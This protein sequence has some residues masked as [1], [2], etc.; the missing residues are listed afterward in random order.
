MPK[1]VMR[2][3]VNTG[4]DPTATRMAHLTQTVSVLFTCFDDSIFR[5]QTTQGRL[6][7]ALILSGHIDLSIVSGY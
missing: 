2:C 3:V 6:G 7:H 1:V 4:H 5:R